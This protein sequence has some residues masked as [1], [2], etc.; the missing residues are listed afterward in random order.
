MKKVRIAIQG[1]GIIARYHARACK[2]I[3]DVELVAAANWRPE[4]LERFAQEWNIPHVT[5]SFAELAADREIDAVIVTV[6]NYLHKDETIRILRA[7]KHVLIEK[8]MAMNASEAQQMV[9]TAQTT[10]TLLMVGH[11]WRF[12]NEVGWLRN[13]I[14][15][16][17]LGDIVRTKG[18][19]IHPPGT[20][21]K[22]WFNERD[23]AGG[24]VIMDMAIHALDTARFLIGDPLP[25]KVY[26]HASTRYS[27]IEV[28]DNATFTVD[29]DNGAYSTIESAAWQ[30][31]AEAPEGGA[32]VW[33]TRGYGRTFPSELHLSL[34]DVLG[35]F[36]P[37]FPARVEQC[38]W[39]MYQ[40]QI[41]HF[42]SCIRKGD[43]PKP[44]GA[45][46]LILMK[47]V[48]AVYKSASTGTTVSI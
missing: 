17:M 29:W 41:E 2:A 38:D 34:G 7:G 4:S 14:E 22:G 5:T 27:S 18:Y 23:K 44:G 9:E 36:T 42:V 33:G 15:H 35:V 3:P 8:P 6:P 32:Q 40:R 11:M 48:D 19:A 39:P 16:G 31:F 25:T 24:G 20:G 43:Q 47:V 46:G 30:P 13:V 1:S 10:G 28:E 21:P 37:T 26:A 12:D 45:E